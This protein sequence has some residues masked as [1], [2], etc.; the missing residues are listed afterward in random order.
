MLPFPSLSATGCCVTLPVLYFCSFLEDVDP[1]SFVLVAFPCSFSF[2]LVVLLTTSGCPHAYP[3]VFGSQPV[4]VSFFLSKL[5]LKAPKGAF[6]RYVSLIYHNQGL[7]LQF[8]YLFYKALLSS[9]LATSIPFLKVG[10]SLLSCN[11]T[12]FLPIFYLSF[13][14]QYLGSLSSATR[15][16]L[17][18][19]TGC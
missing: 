7:C 9:P 1:L 6:F 14:S 19:F 12:V 3:A 8:L 10:V 15:L 11:V 13:T 17:M 18:F 5:W 4:H 2:G 16:V